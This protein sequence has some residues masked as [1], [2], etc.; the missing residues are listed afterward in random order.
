MTSA[1]KT[2]IVGGLTLALIG[3]I[4]G[5]YYAIFDEHQTLVAMI[6]A[7][8]T[9]FADAASRNESGVAENLASFRAHSYEYMREVSVHAHIIEL[10]TLAL[11]I[12]FFSHRISWSEAKKVL[13]ARAFIVGSLVFCLGV[14]SQIFAPGLA[15]QALSVMGAGLAIACVAAL[16]L[17]L[18]QSTSTS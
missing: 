7:F 13:I 2:Y 5:V 3:L 9:A 10:G 1:N 18:F 12:P 4:Y 14:F 17:G 16:V 11:I 6:T 15:T 8:G